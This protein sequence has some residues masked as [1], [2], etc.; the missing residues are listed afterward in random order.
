LTDVLLGEHAVLYTLFDQIEA[1][2]VADLASVQQAAVVLGAVVE[3]HAKLEEELLFPALEPHLGPGG[4]LAVMRAE[5]D[6][7]RQ[8]LRRMTDLS[9]VHEGIDCLTQALDLLRGHF[10]KEEQVLF[11]MAR[12]MLDNETQ[13]R[14]SKAWA[15][16]RRVTI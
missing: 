13:L 16:A 3:P 2:A 8:A 6:E 5:H 1:G 12:Q 9:D 15:A 11:S 7:F 14:L 4:P 10:Q